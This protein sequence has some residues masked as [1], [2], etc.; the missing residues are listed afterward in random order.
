MA[1]SADDLIAKYRGNLTTQEY[2]AKTPIE[3]VEFIDLPHFT[4]DGGIF[5][6]V[7]RLTGGE[8]DW[9]H[10]VAARQ[11]SYSEMTPGVIKGFHLHYKQDDVWFVP[12]SSRM[13]VILHDIRERSA[14]KD[15]TMRFILGGGKAKLVKIPMGVAHGIRNIDSATG[16]V[17]YFVSEQFNR[18]SPDE[19]RLP[20]DLLGAKIWEVTKG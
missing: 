3:G 7:A 11:V 18:E 4:D 10:G 12:P 6:E 8:H 13:L 20:W 9:V 17:F 15:T 2:T 5:I 14:T 19:Q 16:F 1:L